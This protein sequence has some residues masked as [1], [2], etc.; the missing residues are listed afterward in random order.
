MARKTC[1]ILFFFFPFFLVWC[2]YVVIGVF[3]LLSTAFSVVGGLGACITL[4]FLFLRLWQVTK[5]ITCCFK[6]TFASN[7]LMWRTLFT[8]SISPVLDYVNVLLAWAVIHSRTKEMWLH[9][10]W[11][12]L[13]MG[14]Q[15]VILQFGFGVLPL[16]DLS[17]FSPSG[18]SRGSLS[19]S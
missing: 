2:F 12:R 13:L 15:T 18:N 8:N 17:V 16:Q 7:L 4:F 19:V 6:S 11:T 9:F 10:M 3:F 1:L 5:F 14:F